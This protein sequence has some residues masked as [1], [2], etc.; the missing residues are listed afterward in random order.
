M[1]EKEKSKKQSSEYSRIEIAYH[2][3]RTDA[4]DRSSEDPIRHTL[5][6]VALTPIPA[7][8]SNSDESDKSGSKK[9]RSFRSKRSKSKEKE[10][11][12]SRE[13]ELEKTRGAKEDID[14]DQRNSTPPVSMPTSVEMNFEV[15]RPAAVVVAAAGKSEESSPV[16]KKK[17]MSFQ[18]WR[19]QQLKKADAKQAQFE[20]ESRKAESQ[21]TVAS[22]PKKSPKPESVV[23]VA[24]SESPKSEKKFGRSSS[25]STLF[26]AFSRKKSTQKADRKFSTDALLKS[27]PLNPDFHAT[28]VQKGTEES[29]PPTNNSPSFFPIQEDSSDATESP[30]PSKSPKSAKSPLQAW[31]LYRQKHEQFREIPPTV[32]E[33]SIEISD[34]DPVSLQ[35]VRA[36]NVVQRPPDP[37]IPTPD[38]DQMSVASSGASSFMSSRYF[39]NR[40]SST[41]E[42]RPH[43]YQ[44]FSSRAFATATPPFRSSSQFS[45]PRFVIKHRTR[46]LLSASP[47]LEHRNSRSPS[48]DSIF[49]SRMGGGSNFG[50]NDSQIWYQNYQHDA[51]PHEAVFGEEETRGHSVDGRIHHIKGEFIGILKNEVKSFEVFRTID[52]L[53]F[54]PDFLELMDIPL[55]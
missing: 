9:Q 41:E 10:R 25:L 12:A 17:S 14:D 37:D 46:S 40:D 4:R 13:R 54:K 47:R 22:L 43:F 8:D 42:L 2:G 36:D 5:P 27:T 49:G 53:H 35:I 19:E 34:S 20:A 44:N 29:S 33:A 51:F 7:A 16:V 39:P 32:P 31:R 38:Y 48:T 23:V 6:R 3:K 30:T 21:V 26:S 11:R 28:I 18:F 45:I 15:L 50:S 24:N 55:L 1:A 52:S